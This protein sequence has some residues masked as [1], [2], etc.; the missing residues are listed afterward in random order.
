MVRGRHCAPQI[1]VTEDGATSIC[2][3]GLGLFSVSIL[4]KCDIN[5]NMTGS[6]L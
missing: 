3:I 5:D 1:S 4:Q 2:T 6:R